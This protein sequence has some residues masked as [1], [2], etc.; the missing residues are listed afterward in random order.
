MAHIKL[1]TIALATQVIFCASILAYGGIASV[2]FIVFGI[3]QWIPGGIAIAAS[4]QFR[5]N[6]RSYLL[7]FPI[8]ETLVGIFLAITLVVFSAGLAA[9]QISAGFNWNASAIGNYRL[10]DMLPLQAWSWPTY[11]SYLLVFA[12]I[13]HVF[14]AATEEFLWR[15]ALL[16]SL[17][18]RFGQGTAI[19]LSGL[20]WGAW[21]IP[22]VVMLGWVFPEQ[23]VCGSII[24]TMSLTAWGA[25]MAILRLRSGSLWPPIAMHAVLNAWIIGYHDVL[26]PRQMSTWFGPWGVL[27]C[28]V[29]IVVIFT[30]HLRGYAVN[31]V[32]Q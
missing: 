17:L 31:K 2:P 26:F 15:G 30:M 3:C 10:I 27:G 12:P 13:L 1:L 29:A 16:D 6:M 18:E 25:V 20:Y 23:P 28:S 8:E 5:K 7:T 24:F 32:M 9:H 4:P 22:M 19:A 14:N 21:H 11:L